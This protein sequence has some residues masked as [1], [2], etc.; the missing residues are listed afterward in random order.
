MPA[1]KDG[2]SCVCNWIKSHDLHKTCTLH[3]ILTRRKPYHELLKELSGNKQ[4][5]CLENPLCYMQCCIQES[6]MH[7]PGTEGSCLKNETT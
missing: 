2:L 1:K 6:A 5:V 4:Q 7:P 3:L